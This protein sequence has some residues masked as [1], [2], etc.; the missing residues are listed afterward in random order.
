MTSSSSHSVTRPSPG[1]PSLTSSS[2]LVA[3][4]YDNAGDN[5][6][7]VVETSLDEVTHRALATLTLDHSSVCRPIIPADFIRILH[8]LI[9]ELG[10]RR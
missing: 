9:V 2:I 4:L 3:K 6:V 7:A 8:D 10:C 1:A 5:F